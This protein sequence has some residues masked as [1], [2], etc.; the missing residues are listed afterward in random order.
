MEGERGLI[1]EGAESTWSLTLKYG[2]DEKC[3]DI[4]KA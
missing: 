4:V 2:G 3:T 1:T